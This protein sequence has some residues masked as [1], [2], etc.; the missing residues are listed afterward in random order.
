MSPSDFSVLEKVHAIA[1]QNYIVH[2]KV[3]KQHS[4]SDCEEQKCPPLDTTSFVYTTLSLTVI[5]S[6]SLCS[7]ITFSFGQ[8]L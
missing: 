2:V 1:Q 8:C 7:A 4:I 3:I 5:C 6:I